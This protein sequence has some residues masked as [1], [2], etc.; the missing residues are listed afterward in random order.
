MSHDHHDHL[1]P[2]P[3]HVHF[4]GAAL[5]T[6]LGLAAAGAGAFGWA[7]SSGSHTLA[8]GS[9]LVGAFYAL[10]LGVFGTVWIA[11][12]YLT[13]GVWSV[14]MRR[15]P[16][17][18]ASWVLPGGV[19]VLLL[20]VLGHELFPWAHPEAVA[21]DP[22]IAGK[23]AFLNLES[24]YLLTGTSIL[25]W[26][27]F[28]QLIVGNSVKQDSTGQAR[29]TRQNIVLSA[30]FVVLFALSFSV[31]SFYLLMSLEPHWSSTMFA[32]LTYTDV[33]QTG[34]AFVS[35][36]AAYFI[37]SGRL[38]G[39]LNENHLHSAGKM[40]FAFTGFWAY[41]YFCQFMLIWY[42]NI[43]EE[44]AYFM[45]RMD[46]GWLPYMLALPVIKFVVPFIFLAP[47]ENKRRPGRV[48][49]AAI[50]VLFA[51]FL[52]LWLMVAPALGGHGAEGHGG[53][54]AHFPAVE[55]LVTLG[56]LGAMFAVFAWTLGRRA[57]V[58]LKDP[59]IRESLHHHG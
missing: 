51:Q 37:T 20:G 56:F 49:F 8:W 30:V 25:V 52:E 9:Y 24:F 3:E 46:A 35:L 38:N 29:H 18:M 11:T 47:R 40:L 5:A 57:P 15:I 1:P 19:L 23:S 16:E 31:V 13:R 44:T 32:V 36:V 17:A 2:P 14:T 58:P 21:K 59:T 45:R 10:G 39:F 42:A 34:L 50:L 7:L 28:S 4:P 12:L 48:A 54:H 33:M 22:V 41:I 26:F 55:L 6:A 27:L 53:A 43:P